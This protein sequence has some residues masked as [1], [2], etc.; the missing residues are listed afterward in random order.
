MHPISDGETNSDDPLLTTFRLKNLTLRN[1]IVSTSHEPA[2]GEGG[3]PTDR[4]RAYHVEKAR[5]GVALTMIGGSAAVSVDS[6][7]SFGNLSMYDDG[8]V[9]WL[10]RLSDEVHAEGAAVMT[11]LTH[12]GHRTSHFSGPWLPTVSVSNLREPAHR[13]FTKEAEPHDLRRIAADFAAAAVRSQAGGLDGV[14]LEAYGHLLDSF[15]SPDL[16]KRTDSYGGSL[17]NRL[18]FPIEVITAIREAVGP[19]YVL[20]IRM[21][22]DELRPGGLELDE[23]LEIARRITEAGIDFISVIRGHIVTEA[24]L[25]RV[26]PPMGEPSAPH[27]SF[28]GLVRQQVAVP[29]MHAAGISDVATARHAIADGQ[30][31]L[32]GMTR[33]Q[34]A[35]PHLVAKLRRGEEDRIRPCVGASVCIDS[36]YTGEPSYCVHNA[37]TGREL[38]LPHDVPVAENRKAAVVIG[39]GVAGLEAARVLAERGHDVTLYE[40]A[41]QPGG[42]LRLAAMAPRRENLI[43]IVDWRVAECERLGVQIKLNHL[44]EAREVLDADPDVVLVATGGLPN[45]SFLRFGSELV[46]DTWDVL[47]GAVRPG[48]SVLVYD[49]HG[50]HP[51]LDAVEA[52]VQAGADV[53]WASPERT[54]AVD[55]GSVNAPPYLR[56]MASNDVR[57]TLMRRLV[58]VERENGRLKATF[59]SDSADRTCTRVVDHVVVEHGTLPN[60][61]LYHELLPHSSNLGEIALHDLLEL[62]EQPLGPNAD[63]RF[64]L[65][66]IGDAV[67]SRNVH[68]AVLDAFRLCFAL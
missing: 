16:N 5:G 58:G 30:L 6:P 12:L 24:G 61:E 51:G 7:P 33:A 8:I 40:A 68:S 11:Q 20:G 14:E 62:A 46:H 39:A 50:A 9:P 57:I 23:A 49:D 59:V 44:V 47:S 65:F 35:D 31:D 19:D 34:L 55:V 15:W 3:M 66:R 1:R 37:S 52:L 13:S 56:T 10:R 22:F 60:A 18:R 2:Y 54:V 32:V 53:E 28:A 64:Q 43:G 29:V 17:D 25:S 42:Q 27:L 67:N 38:R 26:I 21:S 4:Y 45:T 36:L 63:G 41:D 48:G